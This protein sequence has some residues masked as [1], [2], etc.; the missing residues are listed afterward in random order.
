MRRAADV[1]IVASNLQNSWRCVI[2]EQDSI[3]AYHAHNTVKLLCHET[4]F[5]NPDMWPANSP[6][7][8]PIDYHIL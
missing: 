5:T 6:D 4:P 8:N 3:P 1:R 2:F 7:L